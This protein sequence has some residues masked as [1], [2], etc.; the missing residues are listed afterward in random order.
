M[1]LKACGESK[2]TMVG[3]ISGIEQAL[4]DFR[5]IVFIPAVAKRKCN[6]VPGDLEFFVQNYPFSRMWVFTSG[7]RCPIREVAARIK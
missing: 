4:V 6:K 1:H 3:L 7:S 2:L 5:N